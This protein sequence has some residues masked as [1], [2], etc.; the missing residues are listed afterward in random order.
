MLIGAPESGSDGLTGTSRLSVLTS[1]D[2]VAS[3]A[4]TASEPSPPAATKKVV[5]VLN[6]RLRVEGHDRVLEFLGPDR[7]D[8]V[9]RA[10]HERVADREVAPPDIDPKRLR[11]GQT[12]ARFVLRHQQPRRADQIGIGIAALIATYSS[13]ERTTATATPIDPGPRPLPSRAWRRRRFAARIAFSSTIE[14][15]PDSS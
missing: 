7:L 12:A 1:D 9:A 4:S 11:R 5:Q 6:R 10:D 15:P 2:S 14:M 13:F 3:I 8:H